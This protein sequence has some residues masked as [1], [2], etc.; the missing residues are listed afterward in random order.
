[1][2][3]KSS[4]IYVVVCILVGVILVAVATVIN[5]D[6]A[7]RLALNGTEL[8]LDHLKVS[9]LN[10]AGFHLSNDDGSMP[11]TSFK[12][13]LSYYLGDDRNLSMGGVSVLNRRNSQTPY[14]DCN[15]FEITAKAMDKDGNLTGLQ[16]T[17]EGVDIFG[18]TKEELIS[19]LGEPEDQTV[20]NELIYRSPKKRYKIILTID[21]DTNTCYRIRIDRKEENLVR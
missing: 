1:M 21:N 19:I 15:V 12:E 9:D 3:Q 11:G 5:K 4:M 10:A 18:M 16:V 7:P 13:M 17:Y 2:K 8:D 14:A 20:N 6:T